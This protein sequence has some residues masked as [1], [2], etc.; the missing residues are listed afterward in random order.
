[1]NILFKFTA[2]EA[3]FSNRLVDWH[4]FIIADMLYKVLE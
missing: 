1:M 2:A 4:N 3:P